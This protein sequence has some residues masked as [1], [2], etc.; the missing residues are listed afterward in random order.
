MPN[1]ANITI[2][3]HIGQD[4][5]LKRTPSDKAVCNFSV[6]V[7][8]GF[9]DREVTTWWR[10]TFFG[11]RAEN[12]AKYLSKGSAVIVSGEPQ[13]RP[14]ES[15]GEQRY[16]LEISGNDWGF[17]G[18]KGEQSAAPATDDSLDQEIPF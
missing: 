13:N 3:G 1:H 5:E 10:V 11:K 6:A 9:G 12:A 17:A 16:S 7:K 8:T 14:Y 15:N 4:P 18:G 2:A